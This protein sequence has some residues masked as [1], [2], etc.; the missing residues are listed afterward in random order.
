MGSVRKCA[1]KRT[2][3]GK[4]KNS[5]NTDYDLNELTKNDN[6]FPSGLDSMEDDISLPR[7][8]VEV[9]QDT[10]RSKK[11]PCEFDKVKKVRGPNLCKVVTGLKPGEKLRVRFYHNRVVGDHH[12]LFSRHLGSLVRDRNVSYAST[13]MDRHR[14]S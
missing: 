2:S 4:S 3:N 13:L 6:V 7:D 9:M 8:E 5:T 11:G 10:Q 12:A 1:E 14:R